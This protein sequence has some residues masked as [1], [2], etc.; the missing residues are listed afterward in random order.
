LSRQAKVIDT[1]TD[2]FGDSWDVRERRETKHGFPLLVGWPFGAPRGRGGAGGPRVIV[3]DVL[4]EHLRRRAETY[5]V[6]LPVGRNA[7]VRLRRL[8][9]LSAR[10]ERAAWWFDRLGDL[11]TMTL[12]EFSDRHGISEAAA[13]VNSKRFFGPRVR[14]AGWWKSPE[15]ADTLSMGTADAADALGIS[16]VSVRRIRRELEKMGSGTQFVWTP[17]ADALLGK[18]SDLTVATNLGVSHMAVMMRRRQ[19]G[20]PAKNPRS[21][22]V[23]WTQEMDALLGTDMDS[24]IAGK[25]GFSE[26]QIMSRR[27]KLNIARKETPRPDKSGVK[28]FIENDLLEKIVRLEPLLVDRFRRL[29][30]PIKSL[31]PVQVIESALDYMLDHAE[32]GKLR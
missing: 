28:V 29:R 20:I 3:T 21:P 16:A 9:G 26:N 14:E 23:E 15:L 10:D 24:V 4:A 2:C 19:L 30:V 17:E 5:D 6:D 13:S 1:V 32:G 7:V 27:R 31:E 12:A 18:E 8:L 22:R 25:L 11:I